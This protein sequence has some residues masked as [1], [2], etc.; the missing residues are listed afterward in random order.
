MVSGWTAC[1][2]VR[3]HFISDSPQALFIIMICVYSCN[4][5]PLPALSHEDR[6]AFTH[7]QIGSFLASS[8]EPESD[9]EQWEGDWAA[10]EVGEGVEEIWE[11][12]VS[13]NPFLSSLDV[14]SHTNLAS[15]GELEEV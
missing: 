13:W 5:N 9:I 15:S 8:S 12:A 4:Q 6:R 7:E 1:A 11:R 14:S 3:S 2:R 10:S